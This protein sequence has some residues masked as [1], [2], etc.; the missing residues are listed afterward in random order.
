MFPYCFCNPLCMPSVPP[1]STC[2]PDHFRSDTPTS[3]ESIVGLQLHQVTDI[4]IAT[5]SPLKPSLTSPDSQPQSPSSTSS[6]SNY[7]TMSL[8]HLEP[9][10]SVVINPVIISPR[11]SIVTAPSPIPRKN[12]AEIEDD[13][14]DVALLVCMGFTFC[15]QI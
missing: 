14:E 6:D 8:D 13:N 1:D 9:D 12:S 4:S 15:L 3:A 7:P 10:K 11:K 5:S 2:A